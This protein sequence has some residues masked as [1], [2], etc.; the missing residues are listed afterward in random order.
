MV[1]RIHFFSQNI[2]HQKFQWGCKIY[3]L[4]RSQQLPQI[5]RKAKIPIVF[6]ILIKSLKSSYLGVEKFI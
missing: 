6:K 2:R 5:D 3:T 1:S 4:I